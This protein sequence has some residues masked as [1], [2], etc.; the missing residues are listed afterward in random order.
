[1]MLLHPVNTLMKH[2]GLRPSSGGWLG[3]SMLAALA[4]TL[5]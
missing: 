5:D 4:A 1:M 2:T 3:D